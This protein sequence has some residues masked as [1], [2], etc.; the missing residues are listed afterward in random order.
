MPRNV[1]E[2][3]EAIELQLE[4]PTGWSNSSGMRTSGMGVS[5]T[6]AIP[7]RDSRVVG[8]IRKMVDVRIPIPDDAPIGKD[9]GR[10]RG[11]SRVTGE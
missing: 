1:R 6:D 4:Q 8:A 10:D 11:H 3:A 7:L 2:G 9:S 5:G